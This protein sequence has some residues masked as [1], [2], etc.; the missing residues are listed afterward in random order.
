MLGFRED[1]TSLHNLHKCLFSKTLAIFDT[2]LLHCAFLHLLKI[3][4]R[5]C[6]SQTSQLSRGH[7]LWLGLA[8]LSDTNILPNLPPVH[9]CGCSAS[10]SVATPSA[11]HSTS[12]TKWPWVLA[13]TSS[14]LLF[15][16]PAF[17]LTLTFFRESRKQ[18]L[19]LPNTWVVWLR[20]GRYCFS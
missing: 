11:S 2:P 14:P 10:S 20:G 3:Y 1:M 9:F 7:S 16:H 17:F 5:G 18:L 6:N 13:L 12:Q 19:R 8:S 15:S 4:A